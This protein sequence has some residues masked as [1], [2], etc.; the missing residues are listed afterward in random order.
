M[1][2]KIAA[3]LF[4]MALAA[5]LFLVLMG[6]SDAAQ[7]GRG[8]FFSIATPFV[9]LYG[10]CSIWLKK[11][12]KTLSFWG[13]VPLLLLVLVPSFR[14]IAQF[15]TSLLSF[16]PKIGGRY[17]FALAA[18]DIVIGYFVPWR[19]ILRGGTDQ[20]SHTRQTED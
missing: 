6:T 1:P 19:L 12:R 9:L 14:L 10:L 8:A 5:L 17:M 15:D 13:F 16:S 20:Q 4:L 18:T 7:L 11:H 2:L 3:P